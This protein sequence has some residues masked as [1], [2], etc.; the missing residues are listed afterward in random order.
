MDLKTRQPT[1]KAIVALNWSRGVT[2]RLCI[3]VVCLVLE[4]YGLTEGKTVESFL[5]E[6]L[7]SPA[8]RESTSIK[9]QTVHLEIPLYPLH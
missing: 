8:F 3:P 7:L 4:C 9:I 1:K 5:W 6:A 2:L